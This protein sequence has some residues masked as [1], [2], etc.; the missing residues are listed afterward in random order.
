MSAAMAPEK[1]VLHQ[2]ASAWAIA[3]PCQSVEFSSAQTHLQ[4]PS[5]VRSRCGLLMASA[6]RISH[7]H[8]S[9]RDDCQQGNFRS[10]GRHSAEVTAWIGTWETPKE[11][12]A[13]RSVTA[14]RLDAAS[15]WA[16]SHAQVGRHLCG[17]PTESGMPNLRGPKAVVSRAALL[18][19]C[20][21]A[22]G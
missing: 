4:G 22:P 13:A 8:A 20:Q 11:Q 10:L 5:A 19:L 7:G 15:A 2:L 14:I 18:C 12:L 9:R 21:P 16:T 6:K 1:G 3:P 17:L